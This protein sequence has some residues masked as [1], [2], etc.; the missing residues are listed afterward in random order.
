[1]RVR[2]DLK[3]AENVI[4]TTEAKLGD[5]IRN[6]AILSVTTNRLLVQPKRGRSVQDEYNEKANIEVR[7]SDIDVVRRTGAFT[8]EIEIV[9]GD[10]VS[11]LPPLQDGSN[12]LIDAII[13]QGNLGKT[14]WGE[15][16]RAK[17]GSKQ[18]VAGIVGILGFLIGGI[19]VLAGTLLILSIV[20]IIGGIITLVGGILIAGGSYYLLGWAFGKEEEWNREAFGYSDSDATDRTVEAEW[21]SK[22]QYSVNGIGDKFVHI[23]GSFRGTIGEAIPN[24]IWSYGVLLGC[25]L[26]LSLFGLLGNETAFAWVLFTAWVMLP[27]T[28]YLDSIEVKQNEDWR[29][30]GWA[31]ALLSLI[32]IGGFL[33]GFLWLGRRRQKTGSAFGY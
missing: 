6:N 7:L 4:F 30:R 19:M 17:R 3:E 23:L 20:G 31:Y 11:K 22:I 21:L 12:D 16:S 18:L 2:P 13:E 29:P 5:V 9:C 14:D 33:F 27:V 24:G 8:K 32:P 1:M 28:I 15:E 26:W 25:L 10:N